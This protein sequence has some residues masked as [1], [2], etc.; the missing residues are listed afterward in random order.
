[1][2]EEYLEAGVGEEEEEAGIS[3]AAEEEEEES[4]GAFLGGEVRPNLPF[5]FSSHLSAEED[6]P[7]SP[8]GRFSCAT[9]P[10]RLETS[11]FL[12]DLVFGF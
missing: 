4:H 11:S 3:A 2:E 1:M 8:F 7:A 10:S 9:P 6:I 5:G 12:V